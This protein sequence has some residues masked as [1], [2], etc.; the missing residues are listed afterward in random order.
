MS[1]IYDVIVV[2]AGIMGSSTAYQLS[3]RGL[4]VLLIEQ[5]ALGHSKGSSH[6]SSRII[7]YAHTD[8]IYLPLIKQAYEEW[9]EV[10]RISGEKLYNPCGLLWVGTPES[11]KEKS[12]ILKSYQISHEVLKGEEINSKFPH[13]EYDNSWEALYDPKAGFVYADRALKTFQ[14]LFLANSGKVVENEKI[15]K[16]EPTGDLVE[17]YSMNSRYISKKLVVTAGTWLKSIF[18]ELNIH[19]EPELIGLTF[20]KVKQN[21]KNFLPENKCPVMIMSENCPELYMIPGADYPGEIKFGVHI[22]VSIDPYKKDEVELPQWQV[23]FPAEHIRDHMKDVDFT[24]PTRTVSCMY[25]VSVDV[26]FRN[27]FVRGYE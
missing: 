4:K 1:E 11:T 18:P 15:V 27:S 20:W 14:S 17:V 9:D 21:Q 23:N 25:T 22:G 7:R 6:G 8:N 19:A 3:K 2:G 24:A 12:D 16:I 13:L 5:F 10:S 26:Y